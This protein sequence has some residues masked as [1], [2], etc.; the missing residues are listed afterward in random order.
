M[1]EIEKQRQLVERL[2]GAHK[3][4]LST[5]ALLLDL[6]LFEA[7][8]ER[9]ARQAAEASINVRPHA[10]TH[11]CLEIAKQ[12]IQSGAIGICVATIGEAEIMA[13]SDV[14]GL[15]ITGEMVGRNKIER[16]I[17]TTR[18]QADTM[19]VV[20]NEHHARELSEAASAAGVTL[21]VLVDLDAGDRRTGIVPGKQAKALAE[22]IVKLSNLN[23]MGIHSYSGASSHVEGFQAR[24]THS[25]ESM[26]APLETFFQLK[27]AGLPMEIMTGG[28]TGTYN[29][30]SEIEGMTELQVGSYVFMDI[31]YRRIGSIS[32][33]VYDDFSLSLSVLSTVIS[34][35]GSDQAT[36]DAGIKAFSTDRKMGPQIKGITGVE[37]EIRG[38]EHGKLTLNNPSCD[39]RLGDR[40]EFF[41]PHCDPNVN[42]YDHIFCLRGS[43]VEAV[44]TVSARGYS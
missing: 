35:R 26:R 8:I 24:R 13:A 18:L 29:I 36:V 34:T 44:W 23:L 10:K 17:R 20:D 40:L 39:I 22:L 42:L 4:D 37:Y 16:L 43:R 30:D 32:G 9:M 31:D 2:Q 1:Q 14:K 15:L 41:V 3:D 25:Q 33:P 6:D 11:K 5:P 19:S 21:N 38:D 7:N 27:K 12:Q 28:S